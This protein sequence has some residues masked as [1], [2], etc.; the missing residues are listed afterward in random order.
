[1]PAVKSIVLCSLYIY[2]PGRAGPGVTW[3]FGLC[4]VLAFV[5]CLLFLTDDETNSEIRI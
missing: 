5:E 1:M 4:Y 3:L 2:R